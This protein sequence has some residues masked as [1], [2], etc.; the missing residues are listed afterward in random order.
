MMLNVALILGFLFRLGKPARPIPPEFVAPSKEEMKK[1]VLWYSAYINPDD[2][3][4]W[5][6][7]TFGYGWTVNFRNRQNAALFF[8]LIAIEVLLAIGLFVTV[9]P[10]A[11]PFQIF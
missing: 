6:P 4:G 9:I 8:L 7:K 11:K 3:R 5:V 2:P 1:Y 10:Q